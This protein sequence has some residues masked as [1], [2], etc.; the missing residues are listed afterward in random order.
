[1]KIKRLPTLE[2]TTY[3]TENNRAEATPMRNKGKKTKFE[4]VIKEMK[5]AIYDKTIQ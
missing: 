4:S 5:K 1:M 2:K 3:K